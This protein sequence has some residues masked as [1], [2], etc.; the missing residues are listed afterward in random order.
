M[1]GVIRGGS[2]EM[3]VLLVR[4]VRKCHR[5]LQ[6]LRSKRLQEDCRSLLVFP[7]LSIEEHTHETHTI[8]DGC[9]EGRTTEKEKE[10][11]G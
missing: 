7:W 11:V 9:L 6:W 1:G 4:C 2:E 3:T 5:G 8:P 10:A